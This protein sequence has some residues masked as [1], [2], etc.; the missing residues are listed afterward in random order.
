MF[1]YL[2]I[3]ISISIC[4]YLYIYIYIYIYRPRVNPKPELS[5]HVSGVTRT[6]NRNGRNVSVCVLCGSP[7]WPAPPVVGPLSG[8][9]LC[10][11]PLWVGS[12]SCLSLYKI[13]F[14]FKAVLWSMSSF[15]CYPPECNAYNIAILLH[16]HCTIYV[17]PPTLPLYA[18]HHTILMMAIS[19]KGQ[20]LSCPRVHAAS[21]RVMSLAPLP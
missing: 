3:Y 20:L 6:C 9:P 21:T 12:P 16:A 15:Y 14:H 4:I 8:P 11:G 5:S 17:P 10:V 7:V 13:L 18:I 2:Y 1:I 19:C